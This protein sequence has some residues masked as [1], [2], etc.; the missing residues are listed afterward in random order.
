MPLNTSM[1]NP[2]RRNP[3]LSKRWK[4]Y[5]LDDLENILICRI[6][7]TA[8]QRS[9]NYVLILLLVMMAS[10]RQDTLP[11]PIIHYSFSG[12]TAE[13]NGNSDSLINDGA[14]NVQD[15]F[16]NPSGAYYFDGNTASMTSSLHD[17]PGID[18]PL[19]ISWWFKI[20]RQPVFKDAMDAG[21]IIALVDTLQAI[22]VQM[23]YRAPGYKTKGLDVW[24]WGGGT[25]LECPKPEINKWHHCVYTFDGNTH[26]LFL[27]GEQIAKSEEKAQHGRPNLLMLGNYPGGTQFFKGVLDEIRIYDKALTTIQIAEQSSILK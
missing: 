23:G 6:L 13:E 22:G 4:F 18:G 10:C 20:G 25:I 16:G 3:R 14:K 2:L 8:K 9:K 11:S 1:R 12:N 21:N 24:N 15:R 19:T 17:M 5:R 26:L 7:M 27:N